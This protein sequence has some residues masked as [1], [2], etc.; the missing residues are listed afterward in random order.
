MIPL[1]LSLNNFLCYLNELPPLDFSGIHIACLCGS[2]GHGKSALLDAITWALWGEARGR[3]H[4]DLVYFGQ[5]D[6][7][8]ELEFSARETHYR[9]IRRHSKGRLRGSRGAS[10]LE[11]Q[12]RNTEGFQPLT[13]NTIR[14]DGGEDIIG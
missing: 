8:V 5:D 10:N 4:D 13:G 9:I 3:A 2:N 11:L 14:V 7:W 12:V 1:K 6:M